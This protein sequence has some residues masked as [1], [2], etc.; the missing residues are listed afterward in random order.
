MDELGKMSLEVT[1]GDVTQEVEV[2]LAKNSTDILELCRLEEATGISPDS[3][4]EGMTMSFNLMR[5]MVW[6]KVSALFPEAN[7]DYAT[8]TFDI[9]TMKEVVSPSAPKL[10]EPSVSDLEA[11]LFA[12]AAP[13]T[14]P[15][16]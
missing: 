4:T 15:K 13:T 6:W 9:E 2:D 1:I 14:A 11:E 12:G 3:V 16:V 5:A 8:F 7:I 10:V